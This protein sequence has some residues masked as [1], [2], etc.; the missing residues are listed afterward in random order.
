MN[1]NFSEKT[2]GF[3]A[4]L[5]LLIIGVLLSSQVSQSRVLDGAFYLSGLVRYPAD[6]LMSQNYANTWSL[7]D[8]FAGMLL[9]LGLPAV[10]ISFFFSLLINIG[11]PTIQYL[12][13]R[14]VGINRFWSLVLAVLIALT[15]TPINLLLRS[16]YPLLS[17][18]SWTHGELGI[19]F[20]AGIFTAAVYE[21]FRLA[22]FLAGVFVAVHA[23]W[24]L[25]IIIAVLVPVCMKWFAFK[26]PATTRR[27]L[28]ITYFIGGLVL[29]GISFYF[30]FQAKNATVQKISQNLLST[31]DAAEL[32]WKNWDFHRN[33]P[34]QIIPIGLSIAL[35]IMLLLGQ[36]ITPPELRFAPQRQ[37]LLSQMF[38]VTITLSTFGYIGIHLVQ[39]FTMKFF[40]TSPIN[41]L[42]P[43]R[44][45]NLHAFFAFPIIFLGF[46]TILAFLQKK[47]ALKSKFHAMTKI[48]QIASIS[49]L[50]FIFG[51]SY[52]AS[53]V[54]PQMR[55]ANVLAFQQI[56]GRLNNFPLS[57]QSYIR[58][59]GNADDST[60]F[61]PLC[62]DLKPVDVVLTS[63]E[64]TTGIPRYC[65]VPVVIETSSIDVFAY[66]PQFL[67]QVF[68]VVQDLYG[69][70]PK[71]PSASYKSG[72]IAIS[73]IKPYWES[74]SAQGWSSL[75]CKFHFTTVSAP[76]NWKLKLSPQTEIDGNT[77]YRPQMT[78]CAI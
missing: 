6:S 4:Y 48:G 77:L 50:I 75:A 68:A 45:M 74:L 59:V 26:T 41:F 33:I 56:E 57:P 49:L 47:Y 27:K 2:R 53:L 28:T 64:T 40:P 39:Q 19:L 36:K 46:L 54:I 52:S 55:E 1:M 8:Q 3:I 60:R 61:L 58:N 5:T 38:L 73:E 20:A 12:I 34:L 15:I 11:L 13:C 29:T 51:L 31:S 67:P 78:N 65:N 14:A 10:V 18:T 23:V 42:I 35:A 43:G 71:A 30:L 63:G 22:A 44:F 17:G 76:S 21:R 72:G 24:A 25:F 32:Y 62:R 7:A 69:V 66:T 9:L 37:K 16:D 70:D